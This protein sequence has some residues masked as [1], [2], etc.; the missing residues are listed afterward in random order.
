MVIEGDAVGVV[1]ALNQVVADEGIT[2]NLIAETRLLLENFD[3]WTIKHVRREGN[4]IAHS[5]AKLA[6]SQLQNRVWLGSY[7]SVLSDLVN[8]KMYS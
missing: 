2:T 5:L 8:S 1:S 6:I 7:P 4:K 3:R